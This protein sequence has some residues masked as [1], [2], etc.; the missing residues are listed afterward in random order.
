MTDLSNRTLQVTFIQLAYLNQ[1]W[2]DK[3]EITSAYIV[4]VGR[5]CVKEKYGRRKPKMAF[6]L[7]T[8][9]DENFMR[10]WSWEMDLKFLEQSLKTDFVN[11]E[12]AVIYEVLISATMKKDCSDIYIYIRIYTYFR[13]FE[14]IYCFT[15]YAVS[16]CLK[17]VC[18]F[19]QDY[20]RSCLRM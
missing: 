6:N 18:I 13:S 20:I 4:L 8:I 11:R 1:E 7:K 19:L 16:K 17:N 3:R 12:Q 10:V 9:I 2:W 15:K 14:E 5:A